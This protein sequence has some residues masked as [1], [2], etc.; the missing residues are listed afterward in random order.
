MTNPGKLCPAN[1]ILFAPQAKHRG[2][3]YP[4][5]SGPLP[6]STAPAP[7]ALV[8]R[9]MTRSLGVAALG[10]LLWML[11]SRRC[12]GRAALVAMNRYCEAFIG[13]NDWQ[14]TCVGEPPG[15]S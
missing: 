10:C 11:E 13:G 8:P 14:M 1:C 9:I 4:G 12:V 2:V 3:A 15:A 6:D 5:V 7:E